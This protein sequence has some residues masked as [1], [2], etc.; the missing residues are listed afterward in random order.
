MN[1]KKKNKKRINSENKNRKYIDEESKNKKC[2]KKRVII[3][4]SLIMLV[5][6]YR[7]TCEKL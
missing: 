2:R 1:K 3:Y 7:Y 5:L 6:F 4:I